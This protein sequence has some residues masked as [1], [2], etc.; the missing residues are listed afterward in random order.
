MKYLALAG[1]MIPRDLA[2]T[3][4][5]FMVHQVRYSPYKEIVSLPSTI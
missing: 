4:P 2:G 5:N 1:R 3:D